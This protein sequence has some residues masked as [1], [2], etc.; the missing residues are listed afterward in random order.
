MSSSAYADHAAILPYLQPREIDAVLDAIDDQRLVPVAR[1][2]EIIAL[3]VPDVAD[4][5]ANSDPSLPK[6]LRTQLQMAQHKLES[7]RTIIGEVMAEE[8]PQDFD[9]R[10]LDTA[11]DVCGALGAAID[12][13]EDL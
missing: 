1:N 2:G 8:V 11:D 13:S 7:L 5:I 9:Y 6:Q 10:L 12:I 4:S 3:A